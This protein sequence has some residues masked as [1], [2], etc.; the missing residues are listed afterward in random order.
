MSLLG[1]RWQ[2]YQP[3]SSL[4]QELSK[5]LN[6]STLTA[7][8]LI[9]RGIDRK[10][11]AKAFLEPRLDYLSDPVDIPNIKEAAERVLR[12]RS[13]GEKVL[14]Y[15]DYDVDG[16]TGTSLLISVLRKLGFSPE[17]YI[18]H[19][20][21]E[22]YG[23]NVDALRE[24]KDRGVSLVV[25]VD[26]GI[27]NLI[28]VEFANSLG[29]E[30]LITDHHN[31]PRELPKAVAIVNPKLIAEDHPS[32]DLSGAG[33][34]FKFAW[35]LMRMAGVKDNAFLTE[36]LDLAGLGT[37]ADVVPLTRENRIL[38]V[39]GLEMLNQRKRLGIKYLAEV[40]RLPGR[41]S[42]NHV[43]FALAPRLNAA[44]RLEHASQSVELLLSQD[45]EKGRTLAAEL[46]RTN[47]RRQGIGSDIQ[48]EVFSKLSQDDVKGRKLI[49]LK[50]DDWHPGVIGIVAS[51]IADEHSRPVVLVGVNDGVGRGSARSIDGFNI[52]ELLETC[53]DLYLDFGGHEGA[54]GFEI[55]PDDIP[56]LI[57]RLNE[58]V[59]RK[60]AFEELVSKV[61]IDAE[62]NPTQI[63]LGLIKELESLN[64]HGQGNPAPI[65]ISRSL[66][67]SDWRRVGNGSHLKAKFTDGAI[68]LDTIGFGLGALG[69]KLSPSGVYDIAY[70]LEANEWEGFESAQLNIVDIRE[71]KMRKDI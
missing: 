37:I 10:V 50:G 62:I 67:V 58:G 30:V 2:L 57:M 20:Y 71:G 3:N 28:E 7:Q 51:K 56:E 61:K 31:I 6:V 27:S 39:G 35:I 59:D 19:R 17:Y 46:N 45:E 40:A 38:A 32:R 68:T 65:F 70:N 11:E 26:C 60:L 54:A 15:G 44:G 63:T 64:P 52:F 4:S 12:A 5:N 21:K 24:I 1:K 42:V 25:T 18:P 23:M 53:R 9:N 47:S 43:N 55:K 13:L 16:V 36:H 69:D 14:V 48:E 29:M 8:I 49:V 33:V 66:K 22:G 41:I 34:A